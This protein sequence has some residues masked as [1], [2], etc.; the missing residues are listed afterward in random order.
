MADMEFKEKSAELKVACPVC[1]LAR[2]GNDAAGKDEGVCGCDSVRAVEEQSPQLMDTS[3]NE[4]PVPVQEHDQHEEDDDAVGETIIKDEF[5]VI[6]HLGQGCVTDAY[7]VRNKALKKKFVLKVLKDSYNRNPRTSKRFRLAASKASQLN[8]PNIVAVYE[9]DQNNEGSSYAVTEY[10]ESATLADVIKREGFLDTQEIAEVM[11]QVC[12]ALQ[13]A[14][15]NKIVHRGIKPSNIFLVNRKGGKCSAKLSDFGTTVALP[16]AGRE[17]HF[18]PSNV[19]EFGDPR[20]MSP[21]QCLGERLSP[22]SDIYSLGCTMYE[23]LCGKTP[24]SS[25]NPMTAAVKQMSEEVRPMSERFKDLDIPTDLEAIVMRAL[26]KDARKRY[27]SAE[28]MLNDLQRFIKHKPASM[29]FGLRKMWSGATAWLSEESD[30]R[31]LQVT[32]ASLL[33]VAVILG[34]ICLWFLYAIN[35]E[36]LSSALGGSLQSATADLHT[37]EKQLVGGSVLSP[38]L[39][40]LKD[41]SDNVLFSSTAPS[42][43]LAVED[44]LRKHISLARVDLR[45][46]NLAALNA[47]GADFRAANFGGAIM[48]GCSLEG[49]NLNNA[50][51]DRANLNGANLTGATAAYASFVGCQMRGT[52]LANGDFKG[53]DFT[54]SEITGVNLMQADLSSCK[55]SFAHVTNSNFELADM[56]SVALNGATFGGCNFSGVA[57]NGLSMEQELLRLHILPVVISDH[58]SKPHR[59]LD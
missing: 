11:M 59:R 25:K 13:F 21:E 5:Q 2:P 49:A 6:S 17:T 37:A 31:K 4:T 22:A 52:S 39:I 30:F 42:V 47:G 32:T 33:G 50:R 19:N 12:E 7:L 16:H 43:R 41:T 23:A 3:K 34:L 8:H 35:R 53:S 54:M 20:Y 56:N 26:A 46:Q 28:E 57:K 36:D 38:N 45:A 24:F 1:G 27:Q 55:F 14:H 58:V 29:A 15:A 10:I 51:F 18:R 44:A 48:Q 40:T 9:V